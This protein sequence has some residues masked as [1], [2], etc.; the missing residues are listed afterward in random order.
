[1]RDSAYVIRPRASRAVPAAPGGPSPGGD[2]QRTS[3]RNAVWR[4][5]RRAHRHTVGKCSENSPGLQQIGH[6]GGDGRNDIHQIQDR[7]PGFD[8]VLLFFR[9]D[10]TRA[11]STEEAEV[12]QT[13]DQPDSRPRATAQLADHLSEKVIGHVSHSVR[14]PRRTSPFARSDRPR[15]DAYPDHAGRLSRRYEPRVRDRARRHAA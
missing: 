3:G 7:G 4:S 2:R 5:T 9:T 11:Q 6:V 8:H 1:M 15:P 12:G 10:P 13:I 14:S